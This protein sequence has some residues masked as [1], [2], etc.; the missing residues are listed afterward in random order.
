MKNVCV[1]CGSS[2]GN[3]PEYKQIAL[4]LAMA[5]HERGMGLVYGGGSVGLMGAVARE[6]LRLGC[7]VEGVITQ[8]LFQREVAFKSLPN[9]K[10]VGSMHER[11]ALMAKLADGF[12][13]LP[14]GLGTLDEFFEALTWTQLGIHAKPCGLLNI[15]G[16]YASLA[17]FL[18]H[19]VTE[20]FI[21]ETGLSALFSDSDP[22]RLLD[23]MAAFQPGQIPDKAKF[24]LALEHGSSPN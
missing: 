8:D 24:V 13:A 1:Y 19:A 14:G 15:C 11:K 7:P 5:L 12:V 16:Y 9:L 3:R 21:C 20:G 23:A 22:A 4:A 6:A 18:N 17:N 2:P 10:V